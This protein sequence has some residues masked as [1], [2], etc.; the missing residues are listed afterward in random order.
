MVELYKLSDHSWG[1]PGECPENRPQARLPVGRP[2]A[3]ARESLARPQTPRPGCE[4][5]WD[6]PGSVERRLTPREAA[7]QRADG[8]DRRPEHEDPPAPEEV[9]RTSTEQQEP[10][11]DECIG[12]DDPLQVLLREAQVELD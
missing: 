8:E 4:G 6:R 5:P 3:G 10:A 2:R 1:P 9:G 7:E 12:A 11:E